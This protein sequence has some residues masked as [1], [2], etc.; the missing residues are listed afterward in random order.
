[1]EKF[2]KPKKYTKQKKGRKN[3][4]GK[5]A[6]HDSCEFKKIW[7]LLRKIQAKACDKCER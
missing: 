4:K 3:I 1:M 5:I 7:K 2:A 6:E